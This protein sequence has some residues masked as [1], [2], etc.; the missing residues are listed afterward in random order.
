MS[1][2]GHDR[3]VND[4][5]VGSAI[6]AVRLRRGWTQADLARRAGVSAATVSRVELGRLDTVDLGRLRRLAAPLEVRIDLIARWQGADLDRLLNARHSA[7]HEA[8]ARDFARRPAWAIVPEVSF[9]IYGERGVVD[10]VA[11]HAASGSLLVIELK[12]AIADVNELLGTL[13]R[14]RRLAPRIAAERGWRPRSVSVWLVVAEGRTNRRRV[15]EHRS[16]LRSAL[17]IDGRTVSGWLDRPREPL[18]ALSF[19][20]IDH[21]TWPSRAS[22]PRRTKA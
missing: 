16:T 13:D 19:L 18:A 5:R 14:K 8:V 2:S 3:P 17:P 11:W 20:P 9:S 10:A 21:R 7:M 1:R 15:A 12:T 6:R 4:V 22:R